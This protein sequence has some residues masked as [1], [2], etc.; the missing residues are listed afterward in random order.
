MIF[1]H[2]YPRTLSLIVSFSCTFFLDL[3]GSHKLKQ[4]STL[5]LMQWLFALG[6]FYILVAC[7]AVQSVSKLPLPKTAKES[8]LGEFIEENARLVNMT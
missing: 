5:P 1:Y 4:E 6:T 8:S 2:I 3:G 7:I